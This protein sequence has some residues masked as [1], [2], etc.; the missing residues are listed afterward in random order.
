MFHICLLISKLAQTALQ[1]YCYMVLVCDTMCEQ[2]CICPAVI[3]THNGSRCFLAWPEIEPCHGCF[4][5][6]IPG[7]TAT[8]SRVIQTFQFSEN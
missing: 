6:M 7:K 2:I 1:Y 5:D 4:V 3:S 8:V